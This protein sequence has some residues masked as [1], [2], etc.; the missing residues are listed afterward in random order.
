MDRYYSNREYVD[1]LKALGACNN[2]AR[3]AAVYYAQQFPNRR[4]P[5]DKVIRRVEQRL[6]ETGNLN[7]RKRNEGRPEVHNV[8]A[9]ERI[10]EIV[11][12]DPC[13]STRA[14]AAQSA[15]SHTS[16]H[17]ILRRNGLHPFRPQKVQVLYEGDNQLR[18]NFCRWLVENINHHPN[19]INNILWSDEATFTQE[20]IINTHN[21]HYWSDENPHQYR[22]RAFQRRW[23]INI[24]CGLLKNSVIGPHI[25]PNALSAATYREFLNEN[26]PVLLDD[27]PLNIR[28]V[29]WYQ[30]DGAPPHF[31]LQVRN[32]LNQHF[33]QR[34]IGRGGTVRWPPRS[35]D[36]TP[37]DFFFWGF[38]KEHVYQVPIEN[39]ADILSRIQEAIALID[40]PMLQRVRNSLLNRAN[41]CI[42]VNGG[43]FEHLM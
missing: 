37:L 35:P 20:G 18:L 26:L 41:L 17:R 36:L 38:I 3:A 22:E 2:S 29:L 14:I 32:F 34:W 16:I 21:L 24:W 1:M 31:G 6:I 42:R 5:D 11:E 28:Q 33:P 43:L 9:E 7:P 40:R 39:Q 23:S 19:F 27:I 8:H 13:I 4:Q 12:D 15:L 25:F 30:H 10:L